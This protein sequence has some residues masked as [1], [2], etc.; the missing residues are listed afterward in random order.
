MRR[1]NYETRRGALHS[2]SEQLRRVVRECINKAREHGDKIKPTWVANDALKR[3]DKRSRA[4]ALVRYA[5]SLEC[6]QIAREILR[7]TFEPETTDEIVN[8]PSHQLLE[9]MRPMYPL[10]P[11]KEEEP[12]YVAPEH[13]DFDEADMLFNYHRDKAA[14]ASVI[15]SADALYAWWY[16]PLNPKNQGK[17]A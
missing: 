4:P 12:T 14:G 6:R 1:K 13:D 7:A 16:S 9:N 8:A 5:A 17:R 10:R 3:L 2:Q 15:R 11:G